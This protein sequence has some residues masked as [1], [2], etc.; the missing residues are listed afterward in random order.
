MLI[1]EKTIQALSKHSGKLNVLIQDEKEILQSR[2]IQY[3]KSVDKCMPQSSEDTEVK[4][5]IGIIQQTGPISSI[6]AVQSSA[7]FAPSTP[8]VPQPTQTQIKRSRRKPIKAA[9]PSPEVSISSVEKPSRPAPVI[10]RPDKNLAFWKALLENRSE[11]LWP[12]FCSAMIGIG[13]DIYG[14]GGACFRFEGPLGVIVFHRPHGG[15]KVNHEYAHTQWLSRIE[16][17][18]TVVVD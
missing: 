11:V 16:D 8:I 4:S 14:Q 3:W 12:D 7:D 13:Y 6:E 18:F 1:A 15:D 10:V 2:H 9:P 5:M 17:R